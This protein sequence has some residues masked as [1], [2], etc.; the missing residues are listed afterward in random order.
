[1]N[2]RENAVRKLATFVIL[3]IIISVAAQGSCPGLNRYHR[4]G[5]HCVEIVNAIF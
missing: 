3:S 5:M 2:N 4:A 1:L